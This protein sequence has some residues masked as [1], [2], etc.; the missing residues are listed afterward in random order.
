MRAGF[1]TTE[2]RRILRDLRLSV[3]K[4]YP[5]GKQMPRKPKARYYRIVAVFSL[6]QKGKLPDDVIERATRLN[7][8]ESRYRRIRCP[9][10]QWQPTASSRWMCSNCGYPEFFYH[11]CGTVWNTFDTRGRCPGCQHQWRWTMC[12]SCWAWSRHEDWYRPEPDNDNS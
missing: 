8:E 10:C 6:F 9:V 5:G 7:E 11:A 1:L 2:T 12:L 3:V 4:Y